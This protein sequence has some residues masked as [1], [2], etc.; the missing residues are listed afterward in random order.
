MRALIGRYF[1]QEL[2]L[3]SPFA[4]L[5]ARLL[6][7]VLMA[8]LP[9]MGLVLYTGLEQRREAAAQA[10]D[11]ALRLVRV[12]SANQAQLIEG[13]RQLLIALAELP[14]VRGGDPAACHALFNALLNQ[15]SLYA[16]LG[17][18]DPNGDV[19]CSAVPLTGRVN[20]SDRVYFRRAQKT[21]GFAVGDYQ[22]GRITGKATVNFGYP[23]LD[24]WGDAPGETASPEAAGAAPSAV[25]S[26]FSGIVRLTVG[27]VSNSLAMRSG[28]ATSISSGTFCHVVT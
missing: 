22:I 23:A 16:N 13:A 6:W 25:G 4:S 14:E 19:W 28:L 20:I 5:R 3:R 10:K 2:V 15:Y 27:L 17:V 26:E 7:L 1:S 9:A 12:A 8:I 24:A 18:A 11:E 21:H